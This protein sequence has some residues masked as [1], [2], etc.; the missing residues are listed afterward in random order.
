MA[1]QS[2][3]SNRAVWP[4]SLETTNPALEDDAMRILQNLVYPVAAGFLLLKLYEENYDLCVK[5][6]LAFI[7]GTVILNIIKRRR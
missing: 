3:D 1:K 5:G 6:V 7:I 4:C 2:S